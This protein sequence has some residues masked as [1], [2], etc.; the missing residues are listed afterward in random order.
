VANIRNRFFIATKKTVKVF[1]GGV[2]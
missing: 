1:R 2:S